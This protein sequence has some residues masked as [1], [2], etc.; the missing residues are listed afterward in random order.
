MIRELIISKH[1]LFKCSNILKAG[2]LMRKTKGGGAGT[3]F[4]LSRAYEYVF[5]RAVNSVSFRNENSDPE[6]DAILDWN[7]HSLK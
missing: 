3:H 1:S 6:Q 7:L 5:W 4:K 2:V